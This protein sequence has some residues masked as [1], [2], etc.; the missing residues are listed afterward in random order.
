MM[1]REKVPVGFDG[2]SG[3]FSDLQI[4]VEILKGEGLTDEQAMETVIADPGIAERLKVSIEAKRVEHAEQR[5]AAER[6]AF[7]KS[8]EGRLAAGK[9]TLEAEAKHVEAINA[10]EGLLRARGLHADEIALMTD[11]EKLVEVG[12]ERGT[13]DEIGTAERDRQIDEFASSYATLS[14]DE[15][16]A[17]AARLGISRSVVESAIGMGGDDGDV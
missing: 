9:A 12:I 16:I 2:G 4:A 3:T 17:E 1:M 10:A 5:E 13:G 14:E 15:R 8:P 7:E 11:R 6:R